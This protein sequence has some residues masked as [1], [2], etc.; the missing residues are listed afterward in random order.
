M[1]LRD[2]QIELS[3]ICNAYCSYCRANDRTVGKQLMDTD[4]AIRLVAQAGHME[5]YTTYHAIGE[6]TLHPD[7]EKIIDYGTKWGL[8]HR[9]STNA[10]EYRPFLTRVEALELLISIHAGSPLRSKAIEH[11]HQYLRSNPCNHTVRLTLI[12]AEGTGK[13]AAELFNEFEGYLDWIPAFRM[14]FKQPHTWPGHEPVSGE[15]PDIGFAHPSGRVVVDTYPTPMSLGMHCRMP[16]HFLQV[17]ADGT[18]TPCCASADDWGLPNAKDMSLAEI[19]RSPRML[20]IRALWDE[21][22]EKIPCG[23]CKNA[24]W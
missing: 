5:L 4:L 22:S 10:I 14:H 6:P 7:L 13:F 15:I 23:K 1:K 8:K 12:C 24:V 21:G 3:G 20:E 17:L 2:L 9:I 18:V 19:W 16:Q 11:A